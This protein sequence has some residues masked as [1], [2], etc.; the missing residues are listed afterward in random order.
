MARRS[1]WWRWNVASLA[2]GEGRTAEGSVGSPRVD[3]AA[4]RQRKERKRAG[5]SW[6]R[7][8]AIDIDDEMGG[9]RGD[10]ADASAGARATRRNN[11]RVRDHGSRGSFNVDAT[12][13]AVPDGQVDRNASGPDGTTVMSRRRRERLPERCMGSIEWENHESRSRPARVQ[14]K[15]PCPLAY[16]RC[17]RE[18]GDS[19]RARRR[20]GRR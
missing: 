10:H 18:S 19:R 7:E 4:R 11:R 3:D 15:C 20:R 6:R 1:R 16:R 13:C 5:G 2:G 12:G 8:I 9:V 14:R 17:G